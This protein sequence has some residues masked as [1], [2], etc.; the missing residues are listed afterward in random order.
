MDQTPTLT[1][2][3][4]RERVALP[5]WGLYRVRAKVDTGARTSAIDVAQFEMIDDEHVRFEIVYR[6][7]PVRKT[8]WIEARCVRTSRVKPSSGET[9][10]RIVCITKL[11]L[12]SETFDAELSLVCRKG[13][14]CRMLIGR[15]ALGGR[16]VVDPAQKYMLPA[17]PAPTKHKDHP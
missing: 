14:L 3:G 8:K 16:F 2:T 11:Q 17:D 1:H 5:D 9:Q 13:M 12:G 6:D 4:W 15:S 10:E 7:R